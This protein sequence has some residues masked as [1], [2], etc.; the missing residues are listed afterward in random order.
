MSSGVDEKRD[1]DEK[2]GAVIDCIFNQSRL[3]LPHSGESSCPSI[4]LHEGQQQ[5][6]D[7]QRRAKWDEL[8]KIIIFFI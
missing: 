5:P 1:E 7:T 3:Y 8:R 2:I 6:A 4:R